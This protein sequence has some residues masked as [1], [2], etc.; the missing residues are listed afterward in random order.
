MVKLGANVHRAGGIQTSSQARLDQ[1]VVWSSE[2][3]FVNLGR[4]FPLAPLPTVPAQLNKTIPSLWK[5][6]AN[7]SSLELRSEGAMGLRCGMS[8]GGFN[9]S[10]GLGRS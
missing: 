4:D 1:V 6:I 2:W 8:N 3:D 5:R 9:A 7:R 10:A